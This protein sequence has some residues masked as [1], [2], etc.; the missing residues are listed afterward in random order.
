MPVSLPEKTLEHWS[1]AYLRSRFP[2][3]CL[4][5]PTRGEDIAV[6]LAA[7]AARRGATGVALALEV[8]T[9]TP[10]AGGQHRVVVDLLQ[11]RDYLGG[12]RVAARH[13][14]PLPVFYVFPMPHWAGSLVP[15]APAL[16]AAGP[17]VPEDWWRRTASPDWFGDW[18][19]VMSAQAVDVALD[20]VLAPGGDDWRSKLAR[21]VAGGV[22]Q[23]R[24]ELYLGPPLPPLRSVVAGHPH[25]A[26]FPTAYA[27]GA[28]PAVPQPSFLWPDFWDALVAVAWPAAPIGPVWRRTALPGGGAVR[29]EELDAAG[30]V[31]AETLLTVDEAPLTQF[32]DDDDEDE[33]S[34]TSTAIVLLDDL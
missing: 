16:P 10:R 11:L 27:A 28:L 14:L 33:P 13:G 21:E 23:P 4:W 12:R 24:A 26:P 17:S 9:A 22:R 15:G 2:T 20:V 19:L 25:G 29:L 1:S 7:A 31:L 8:K 32:V 30:E 34:G 3:S 5:W 6:D 18:T